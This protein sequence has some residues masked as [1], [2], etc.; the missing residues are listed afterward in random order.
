MNV[1][2]GMQSIFIAIL[3]EIVKGQKSHQKKIG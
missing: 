3:Y 2:K 1:S